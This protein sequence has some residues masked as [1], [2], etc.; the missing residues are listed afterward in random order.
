MS[1]KIRKISVT[2][3]IVVPLIIAAFA[4]NYLSSQKAPPRKKGQ[5]GNDARRVETIAYESTLIPSTLDV[6]GR[7]VAFDKIDILAEVSGILVSTSNTFKIGSRFGKGSV[8]LQ[9]DSEEAELNLLSQKSTLQNA[10]TQMMPDLKIDYPESFP[11]WQRY[12]NTLEIDKPLPKLPKNQLLI[13]IRMV[14]CE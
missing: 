11:K 13:K 12:F 10:I 14:V 1:G 8:M 6:Q 4:F 2:A 5:V 7:L 3:G 9:I